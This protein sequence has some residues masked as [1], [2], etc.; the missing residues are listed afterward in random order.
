[1]TKAK[2]EHY[3]V[4]YQK[5]YSFLRCRHPEVLEEYRKYLKEVKE[6]VEKALLVGEN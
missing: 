4:G 5:L 3:K 2:L 6:R 1:M